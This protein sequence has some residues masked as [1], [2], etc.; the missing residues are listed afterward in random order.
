[1][2]GQSSWDA[3][4]ADFLTA[5]LLCSSIFST[6]ALASDASRRK[7]RDASPCASSASVTASASLQQHIL[8][9]V[10]AYTSIKQYT[11]S[12]LLY[13]T[14]VWHACCHIIEVYCWSVPSVVHPLHDLPQLLQTDGPAL[15]VGASTSRIR[16]VRGPFA[17]CAEGHLPAL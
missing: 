15:R 3:T 2:A 7:P 5:P 4:N 1:M 8:L 16:I 9:L 12:N 14:N 10:T 13:H 11:P 6:K 17:V